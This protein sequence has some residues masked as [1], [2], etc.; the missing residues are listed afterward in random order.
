MNISESTIKTLKESFTLSFVDEMFTDR[1]PQDA[2]RLLIGFTPEGEYVGKQI[3]ATKKETTAEYVF[4]RISKTS[5]YR[6]FCETFQK[7]LAEPPS[8]Q[9]YAASYG[10]GVSVAFDYKGSVQQLKERISALLDRHQIDYKTE[11]SEAGW[12][13]RYKISQSVANIERISQLDVSDGFSH[14]KAGEKSTKIDVTE[15]GNMY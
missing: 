15:L 4:A 7:L 9:V 8:V 3:R 11:H 5:E 6:N 1:D 14:D 12:V 13:F 2:T 10:L